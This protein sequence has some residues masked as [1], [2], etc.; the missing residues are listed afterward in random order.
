VDRVF[1]DANV[2]FSAAYRTE[3]PLRQLFAL[4]KVQPVTSH[5]A[6]DEATRNLMTPDQQHAL[7]QLRVHL[8]LVPDA[9][10]DESSAVLAGLPENDRPILW[11]AITGGATHLL[12][13]DFKAFGKLYGSTVEGVL[14]L[15]PAE[16][17]TQH[18][19]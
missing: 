13:G 18:R 5:Y 7:A 19:R 10:V 6:F 1:L 3:S 8:E 15:P 11:G 4:K 17:L 9:L 14:I 12:S 16:Y 2:L